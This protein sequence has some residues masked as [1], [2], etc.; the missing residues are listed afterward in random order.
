[1]VRVEP[2]PKTT[3]PLGTSVVLEVALS[4]SVSLSTS[5][6]V[7]LIVPE[8]S[9]LPQVPPGA[10]ANVGASLTGVTVIVTVAGSE[11]RLPSLG[12]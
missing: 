11:V 6:T 7:R 3:L 4:V 2:P 8:R 1:M 9:L 10:T 5:P 12:W